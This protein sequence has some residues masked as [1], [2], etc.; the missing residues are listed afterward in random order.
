[1]GGDQG[2]VSLWD[3]EKRELFHSFD[4]CRHK[5]SC[6]GVAFSPTNELLLCTAGLDAKIQ[7]FDV[8]EKKEVK[9]ITAHEPVSCLAFYYDG[10][11]IA[12]GTV[13]GSIYIYNLKDFKV[14]HVLTGHRTEVKH[15]EFKKHQK[16]KKKTASEEAE[17][18]LMKK[19]EEVKEV[20]IA[21]I[22]AHKPPFPASEYKRHDF[23]KEVI[24]EDE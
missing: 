5:K 11:T 6:F 14:R 12:A 16:K 13:T 24:Q 7:F 8:T 3:V 17:E 4:R 22:T 2:V 19:E 9:K 21:T 15:L 1:M 20:P 23:T 10:V 18:P